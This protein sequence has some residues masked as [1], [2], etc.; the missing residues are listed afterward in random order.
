MD[1]GRS[2]SLARRISAASRKRRKPQTSN[3]RRQIC[4]HCKQSLTLKTYKKHQ[5]L[6]LRSDKTW[7]SDNDE[8]RLAASDSSCETE[9]QSEF[10]MHTICNCHFRT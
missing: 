3:S 5:K 9:G 7:M 1:V 10:S 4:P 2:G 8:D 6:F